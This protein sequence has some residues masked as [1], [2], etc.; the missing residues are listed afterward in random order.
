MGMIDVLC[1]VQARCGSHRLPGKVMKDLCGKP[2]I[3]HILERLRKCSMVDRIVVAT[4]NDSADTKLARCVSAAGVEVVRGPAQNVLAR[5][6]KVLRMFPCR[7]V[8]RVCADSPLIDPREVDRIIKHHL[9]SGAEYSFN[10]IPRLGNGYPDGVGAEVFKSSVLKDVM[11]KK[12]TASEKEHVNAYIWNHP[13]Q[14]RITTIKAP[15]NIS[16]PQLRFEVNTA[17]EYRFIKKIYLALYRGR[18]FSTHD[19][20]V[21]LR[22]QENGLTEIAHV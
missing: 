11:T 20:I 2:L 10:H 18:P 21:F 17:E 14:Y 19:V 8:V 7:Q 13:D 1:C 4:T 9:A 3:L 15:K 16:F 6:N 12:T 5:F 22:N